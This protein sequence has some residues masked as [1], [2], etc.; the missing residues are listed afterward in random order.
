MKTATPDSGRSAGQY[1]ELR[2][3]RNM[4][5]YVS[6]F[7]I[8]MIGSPLSAQDPRSPNWLHFSVL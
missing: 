3:G 6:A 7:A 1:H 4:N 8:L 2:K 5:M